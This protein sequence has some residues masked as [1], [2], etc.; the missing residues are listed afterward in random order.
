ME[1]EEEEEEAALASLATHPYPAL[2]SARGST[3][4]AYHNMDDMSAM[5]LCP[6][7]ATCFRPISNSLTVTS[8]KQKV[9]S[10]VWRR[11]QDTEV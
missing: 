6:N 2:S 9:F 10:D 5:C 8:K 7:L 4:Q 1:V 11:H 3:N